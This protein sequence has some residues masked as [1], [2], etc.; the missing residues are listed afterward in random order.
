MFG[1]SGVK[2]EVSAET[3]ISQSLRQLSPQH[4]RRNDEPTPK[5]PAWNQTA[6]RSRAP[7]M[8]RTFA[9]P[10][11]HNRSTVCG[12]RSS[13]ARVWC[14]MDIEGGP[15][16]DILRYYRVFESLH[17][18]TLHCGDVS[19]STPASDTTLPRR[20]MSVKGLYYKNYATIEVR[21]CARSACSHGCSHGT[22]S[23]A[24]TAFEFMLATVSIRRAQGELAIECGTRAHIRDDRQW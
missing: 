15:D 6:R 11:G 12:E 1:L 13:T 3:R 22:A 2:M 5:L 7:K 16:V 14:S 20:V 18:S 19:M 10:K 17:T 9:L 8:V 4:R 23:L 21:P 24:T